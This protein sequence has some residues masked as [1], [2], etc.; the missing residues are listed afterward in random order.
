VLRVTLILVLG[1]LPLLVAAWLW[2]RMSRH[3]HVPVRL[4]S[5]VAAAGA[6]TG[7]LALYVERLVLHWTGLSLKVGPQGAGGALLAT[8]LLAAPLEEG[9]KVL[10]VWPLYSTRRITGPRLGLSFAATA[11][12]GFAAAFAVHA[13]WLG[14]SDWLNV[15]RTLLGTFAQVF[16][17]GVWG[18]ALGSGRRARGRWFSLSWL[19]AMLLH[20]LYDHIV[21]GHGPGL[22]VAALP[23]LGLMAMFAWIALRDVA[24]ARDSSPMSPH[25]LRRA[26]PEPPSLRAMRRALQKTDRPLMVQWI[27][28]GTLVTLGVMI[29]AVAAAVFIG[30]RLGVDFAMADEADVRS[31][32]PLV[33]IGVAVLS[34]F[35]A[36]GY[37]IA[38]ASGAQSVLEPALGAGLAIAAVLAMLSLT[39]PVAVVFA[40]AVAPVAFALACGGAWFGLGR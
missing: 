22:L 8:F 21:F 34:A 38:R 1:G 19:A 12:A 33:L 32:G 2:R 39:A 26:L 28:L 36:A 5:L 13:A 24:P 18:Y 25:S 15:V 29:V 35:P 6:A 20:G 37:L 30:H 4:A 14:P 16:F 7:A 23:M 17:A 11:A 40:L 9:L 3:R 10:V 31:S 27:A